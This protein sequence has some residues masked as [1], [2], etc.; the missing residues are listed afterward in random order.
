MEQIGRRGYRSGELAAFGRQPIA[1]QSTDFP[2]EI[3]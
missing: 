1:R 2:Y 3:N